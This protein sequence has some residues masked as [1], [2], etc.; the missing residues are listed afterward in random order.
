[1]QSLAVPSVTAVSVK[2]PGWPIREAVR[3]WEIIRGPIRKAIGNGDLMQTINYLIHCTLRMRRKS[4]KKTL[5]D[6]W[7]SGKSGRN[8]RWHEKDEGHVENA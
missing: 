5:T 2:L 1:M 4:K 6:Q 3:P 8:G 7:K